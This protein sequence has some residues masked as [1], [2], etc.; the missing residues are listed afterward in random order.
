MVLANGFSA[1][2]DVK[3]T[4]ALGVGLFILKP[5]T[6]YQLGDLGVKQV[7][8]SK[9][10]TKKGGYDCRL[11][12]SS[13]TATHRPPKAC[14]LVL[15]KNDLPTLSK[16][17]ILPL[18]FRQRKG[19][20]RSREISPNKLFNKYIRINP[21]LPSLSCLRRSHCHAAS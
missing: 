21:P 6:M 7:L 11:L 4:Q 19:H 20:R 18:Y 2:E 14:P 10:C 3:R 15:P 1:T 9:E 17:P 16:R 8:M 12:Y 13:T 5:Y